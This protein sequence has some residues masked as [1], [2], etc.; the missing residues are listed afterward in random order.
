M[1]IYH[2]LCIFAFRHFRVGGNL[3]E[4]HFIRIFLYDQ[5]EFVAQNWK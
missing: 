4:T 5:N 3:F 2:P 1:N